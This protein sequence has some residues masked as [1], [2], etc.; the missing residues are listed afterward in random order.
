MTWPTA[1]LFDLDGT[2]VDSAPDIVDALNILLSEQGVEHQSLEAVTKMIGGGV[3]LLIERALKARGQSTEENRIDELK[4]RFVEIYAPRA[5]EK[6]KLFPGVLDVLEAYHGD[7]VKLGVCTNKPE[8][9]T[10]MMLE[11]LNLKHLFSVVI[12]GDTL[13]VK[14]PD[15][16]PL[17][18]ALKH[19]EC[20]ASQAVM[21]G[22]SF[23]DADAA[24]A[25]A[26][27]VI[28][29]TFGYT[30]TPAHELHHDGLVDSFTQLPEAI[31]SLGNRRE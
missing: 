20:D 22:D 29:V 19:L 24:G 16:A 5:A 21:V 23:T 8:A 28:L 13:P 14:K 1:I 30:Q 26:I 9:V 6:T 15:P 27:P 2:L 10:L 11:A 4:T 25:A 12:G 31:K 18:A 3:P 7:G 17:L